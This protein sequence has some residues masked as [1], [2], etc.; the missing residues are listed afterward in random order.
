[1]DHRA[2]IKRWRSQKFLLKRKEGKREEACP[3]KR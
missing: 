2:G 3:E 1:M